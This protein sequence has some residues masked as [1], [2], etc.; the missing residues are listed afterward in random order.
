VS[1]LGQLPI[2]VNTD[3]RCA[4]RFRRSALGLNAGSRYSLSR[5]Y[6]PY[7]PGEG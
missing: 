5:I 7:G 4:H 2:A 3:I 1:P 6:L